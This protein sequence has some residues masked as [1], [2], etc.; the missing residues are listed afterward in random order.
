ML[1]NLRVPSGSVID[2]CQGRQDLPSLLGCTSFISYRE[3]RLGRSSDRGK[4]QMMSSWNG[5]G[6]I[7]IGHR[8]ND[9]AFVNAL[10]NDVHSA[11]HPAPPEG[12]WRRMLEV[13]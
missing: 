10:V 1:D 11:E 4:L 7:G 8:H 12:F 2:L 13:A 9:G 3:W 6:G 5:H